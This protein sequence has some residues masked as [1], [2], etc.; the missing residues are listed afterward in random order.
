M[1]EDMLKRERVRILSGKT[2]SIETGCG[3]LYVTI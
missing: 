1:G 2:I 3:V